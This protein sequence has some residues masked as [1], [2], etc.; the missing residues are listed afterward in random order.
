MLARSTKLFNAIVFF[1][2]FF[3]FSLLITALKKLRGR[4]EDL[5]KNQRNGVGVVG[6][7]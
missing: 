3:S 2:F 4:V 6:A 1:F 7:R 5:W